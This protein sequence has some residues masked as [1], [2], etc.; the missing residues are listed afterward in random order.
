M[1]EGAFT[2]R[3]VGRSVDPHPHTTREIQMRSGNALFL[4]VLALALGAAPLNIARADDLKKA[5]AELEAANAELEA[6]EA[7][8]D[9]AE[10]EADLADAEADLAEAEADE[11]ELDAAEAELD[12]AEAELD[13]AEEDE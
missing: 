2:N 13:A 1:H 9:L 10:A 4:C 7:E 12:A 6:A 3:R 5:E 8:A 11:A